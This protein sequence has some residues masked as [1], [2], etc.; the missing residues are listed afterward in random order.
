MTVQFRILIGPDWLS[1]RTA[2]HV[3]R[4]MLIIALTLT[5]PLK[6]T[7]IPRGFNVGANRNAGGSVCNDNPKE[8]LW[9]YCTGIEFGNLTELW[10]SDHKIEYI[11]WSLCVLAGST[12]WE[13]VQMKPK[14][15]VEKLRKTKPEMSRPS[16][17][18]YLRAG[19]LIA[20]S[21]Q[22]LIPRKL[23]MNT[24]ASVDNLTKIK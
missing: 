23:S 9:N 20:I 5:L 14:P 22:M 15:K 3:I 12:R 2:V 11:N 4:E 13:I 7:Y 10:E 1:I 18:I 21:H 24:L 17:K 16:I 6:T 8:S 19:S